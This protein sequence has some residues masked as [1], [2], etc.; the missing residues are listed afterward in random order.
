MSDQKIKVRWRWWQK[1]AI[2][3]LQ[4]TGRKKCKGDWC[5]ELTWLTF[6][7][8]TEQV[9][10]HVFFPDKQNLS[11]HCL[12]CVWSFL[13]SKSCSFMEWCLGKWDIY[14]SRDVRVSMCP[15]TAV[16]SHFTWCI[17]FSYTR[18][19]YSTYNWITMTY[20]MEEMLLSDS[21]RPESWQY[22]HNI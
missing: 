6:N 16:L 9:V 22:D 4:T 12:E 10:K 13:T 3:Q 18:L 20:S 15:Y 11:C 21:K 8:N 17:P 19:W 5:K 1:S 14:S 7:C 2:G